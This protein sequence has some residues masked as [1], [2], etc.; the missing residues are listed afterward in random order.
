MGLANESVFDGVLMDVIQTSE[1]GFLIGQLRVP[2]V[3]PDLTARL[4][5][6]ALTY[7]AVA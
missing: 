5:I 7:S 1:I 2:E 6:A 3:R 4:F